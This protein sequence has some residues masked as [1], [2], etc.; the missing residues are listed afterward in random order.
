M[1]ELMK[2]EDDS[3]Q[4]SSLNFF[5][6]GSKAINFVSK[7]FYFCSFSTLTTYMLTFPQPE[8]GFKIKM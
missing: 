4:M 6:Y 8:D 7:M 2:N 5:V 1:K 3:L